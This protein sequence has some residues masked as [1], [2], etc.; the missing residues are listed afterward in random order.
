MSVCYD[1]DVKD[2]AN[3]SRKRVVSKKSDDP[4]LPQDINIITKPV[5]NVAESL[6]ESVDSTPCR[7]PSKRAR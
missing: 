5:G 4:I 3:T 6:I 2:T 7:Q 1:R